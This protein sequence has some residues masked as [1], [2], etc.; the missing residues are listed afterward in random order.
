MFI[1]LQYLWVGTQ[2]TREHP[3]LWMYNL[4]RYIN[5]N[6]CIYIYIYIRIY[7][8]MDMGEVPLEAVEAKANFLVLF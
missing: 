3:I 4:V 6:L 2:Y 5:R 7:I 8:Y 1:L